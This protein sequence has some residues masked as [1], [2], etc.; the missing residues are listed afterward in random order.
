MTRNKEKKG[1]KCFSI[2]AL[3]ILIIFITDYSTLFVFTCRVL[4][5]M[6]RV[7]LKRKWATFDVLKFRLIVRSRGH[8]PNK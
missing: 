8:K 7:S 6:V 4:T 5:D 3:Y 2:H 1:G